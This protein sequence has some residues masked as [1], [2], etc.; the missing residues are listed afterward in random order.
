MMRPVILSR[1]ENNA[2]LLVIFCDG[3]SAMTSS[4]GCGDVSAGAP[5]GGRWPGGERAER[6]ARVDGGGAA[7]WRQRL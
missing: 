3:G 2:P 7:G 6:S 1:P 5:R 4:P